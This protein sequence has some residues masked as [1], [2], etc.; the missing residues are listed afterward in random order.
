MKLTVLGAGGSEAVPVLYCKCKVCSSGEQR[1]RPSYHLKIS[2]K[3]ELLIEASPD[4]RTQQLNFNFDFT[5]CFL[6]HEHFD[7]INGL[8]EMR[9]SFVIGR[10][11]LFEKDPNFT[12]KL[13]SPKKFLISQELHDKFYE[14]KWAES[15]GCAYQELIQ[16]GIFEPIILQPNKFQK[17]DDFEIAIL[18]NRH[19]KAISNGF[20]LKSN[21]K[22]IIYL[23]DM[24]NMDDVTRNFIKETDPN[25]II[26]HLPA[27]YTS[28]WDDHIGIKSLEEFYQKYKVLIGHISHESGLLLSD[29]QKE[30]KKRSPNLIVGY[31]G[32]TI[33]I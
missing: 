31:D 21:H 24:S 26:F 4:F 32:L 28:P 3:S 14:M 22:V 29:M 33:N 18:N 20:I 25:L 17:V 23:A 12:L 7:H 6:S 27:F 9:Q 13:K 15:V 16:E 30:A 2:D 19:D 10:E 8:L 11:Y 1:L 5:H